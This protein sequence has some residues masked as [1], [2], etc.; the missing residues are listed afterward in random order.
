MPTYD[1]AD[2]RPIP[3]G[4]T[5]ALSF[6]CLTL[7]VAAPAVAYHDEYVAPISEIP[8]TSPNII[9]ARS[10]GMGGVGLAIVDDASALATNPAALARLR[11]M[12]LAGGLAFRGS[13]RTGSAFGGDIDTRVTT[14]DIS[15]LRFAY[16]FPTFRGSLVVGLSI[17]QV[18]DLAA[19]FLVSYEDSIGW[20]EPTGDTTSVFMEGPW[21]QTEDFLTSG[22]IYSLT[23]GVAFDASESVSLGAAVSYLYG[24]YTADFLYTADDVEGLSDGYDSYSLRVESESDVTGLRF[25]M[26]TLLY[27]TESLSAGLVVE[28]PTI[29]RFSGYAT[30]LGCTVGPDGWESGDTYYFEDDIGLPFSFG[31]G[32]AWNPTDLVAVGFD[33][34]YANWSEMTY[35]GQIFAG[36]RSERER[37]YAATSDLRVGVEVTMPNLPLR[38]RGGYMTRPVAYQGLDIDQD[39]AYYTLGAGILVDTVFTIDVAWIAGVSERS[40]AD[41]DFDER[42]KDSALVVEAAYHF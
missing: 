28:T 13:G 2:R 35:E 31:A 4:W 14:T 41:F 39:R 17:D 1:A 3:P 25:R 22:G 23:F 21:G 8:L 9:G 5:V 26:G 12:E 38:L 37:T 27:L 42:I 7:V 36:E 33:Y 30:E 20:N 10:L 18:Y 15:S 32:I 11:R 24:N 29:L 6:F 16:P 19:D 40:G 34:H